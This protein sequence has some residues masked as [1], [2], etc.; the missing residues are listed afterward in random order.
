MRRAGWTA[1]LLG[2]GFMAMAALSF[3]TIP[4]AILSIYTD[5]AA[6]LDTAVL[7]LYIAAVFQIF[8]GT[9]VVATGLLRGLGDTRTALLTNLVGHWVLGLP[10]GWLLC[11]AAGLGV[12]G[13]WVGLSIGLMAVAIMLLL[14][15]HRR[16][17]YPVSERA[18][19]VRECV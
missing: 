10:A 3:F 9:Q 8:D 14:V 16:S 12:Y 15:W 11:Y 19:F 17:R 5:D 7:L 6:L 4:R 18:T 13:I 1:L 2:A